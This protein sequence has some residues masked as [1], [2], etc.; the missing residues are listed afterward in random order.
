MVLEGSGKANVEE[1]ADR[2][3]EG[4]KADIERDGIIWDTEFYVLLAE[5]K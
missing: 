1:E 5:K 4:A 2:L 3:T